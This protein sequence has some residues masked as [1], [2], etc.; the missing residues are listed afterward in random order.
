MRRH[1]ENPSPRCEWI[2]CVSVNLIPRCECIVRVLVSPS[3]RCECILRV[4]VNPSPRCECIVRVSGQFESEMQMHRSRFWSIRIRD[5]NA[6]FAFW[7]IRARDANAS[8]ACWSTNILQKQKIRS[9]RGVAFFE[10]GC[11][12]MAQTRLPGE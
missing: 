11:S 3:P 12:G 4:L 2:V 8:F 7:S 6:S 9:S 5:A 1:S 10:Q